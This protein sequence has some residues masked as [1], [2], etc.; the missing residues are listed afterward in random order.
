MIRK[1]AADKFGSSFFIV[2]FGNCIYLQIK[3]QINKSPKLLFPILET[4]I[5]VIK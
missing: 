5:F 2:F 1:T 3:K 4:I